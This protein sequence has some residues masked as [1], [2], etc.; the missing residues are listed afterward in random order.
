MSFKMLIELERPVNHHLIL[1]SEI[2]AKYF[3]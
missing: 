3:S 1:M 2:Y